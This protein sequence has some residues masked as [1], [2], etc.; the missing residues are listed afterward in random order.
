MVAT[1]A[2]YEKGEDWLQAMNN[3]LD[4]NFNYLADFLEKELPHAEFKIPEATYLAW[5]DLSYYIKRK[6]Y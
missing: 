4:D 2:A 6:R 3:Y 5:V 1:Q